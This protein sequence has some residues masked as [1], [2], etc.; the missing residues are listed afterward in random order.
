MTPVR[1]T[2]SRRCQV[3]QRRCKIKRPLETWTLRETWMT[4]LALRVLI[5]LFV[6]LSAASSSIL[7]CSR[8]AAACSGRLCTPDHYQTPSTKYSD[9]VLLCLA[10]LH[11]K[12][13]S[14]SG[15][16]HNRTIEAYL[17][18]SATLLHPRLFGVDSTSMSW[19]EHS[20]GPQT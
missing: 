19:V 12:Y 8:T 9:S 18:W 3:L 20:T 14:L 7:P 17:P 16:W 13:C 6:S 4:S 1:Y 11:A 2:Q 10:C 5:F 15:F